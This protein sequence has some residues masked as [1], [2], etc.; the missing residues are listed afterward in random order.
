MFAV[1]SITLFTYF[2]RYQSSC[3]PGSNEWLEYDGT[4]YTYLQ[5]CGLNLWISLLKQI[6]AYNLV[7]DS[8]PL[9]KVSKCDQ[10]GVS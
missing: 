5:Y 2:L 9:E 1:F 8:N 6:L 7:S 4:K 10:K 3:T